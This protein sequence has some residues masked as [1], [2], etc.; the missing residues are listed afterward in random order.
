MSSVL[1]KGGISINPLKIR[2]HNFAAI[3]DCEIDLTQVN[4]ASVIGPNGI[5][6]SSTFV[7]GPSFCLY[8]VSRPGCGL[9][10]LVKKGET[11]MFAQFTFEHNN[12][13]WQ[14]VRTRSL[15]GRGKSSAEFQELVNG[16]WVNRSGKTI[17]ETD[18]IIQQLLGL[19][20]STFVASSL[21]IQG[22]I[23]NFTSKTPSNRK[24]VLTQ[25]L[26]LDLYDKLQSLAKEKSK[27]LELKLEGSKQ[28][29]ERLGE[30]MESIKVI[31]FGLDEV[32]K[33]IALFS[34]D[35][36]QKETEL[37][38]IQ[39]QIKDLEAKQQQAQQIQ[40]KI[41]ALSDEISIKNHEVVT[42]NNRI[43][44]AETVLKSEAELV[45]KTDKLKALRQEIIELETKTARIKELQAE[46]KQL[47]TEEDNLIKDG[48]SLI[49]K[50]GILQRELANK[51]ELKLASEQYQTSLAELKG[52]DE[53]AE[54]WQELQN[55]IIEIEKVT[56]KSGDL[57][58]ELQAKLDTYY[59]KLQNQKDKLAIL[60]NSGCPNPDNATC[61]FLMDA[62][63]A[64][65]MIPKI[66]NEIAELEAQIDDIKT[67]RKPLI[68]QIINLTEQQKAIDYVPDIYVG[69]KQQTEALRLKAE[70]YA[71]LSGKEELLLNLFNQREG[72][73]T[74]ITDNQENQKKINDQIAVLNYWLGTL[75]FKQ[76]E[77]RLLEPCEKQLA[78]IPQAKAVI[79][80]AKEQIKKLFGEIIQK[81]QTQRE[82]MVALDALT[83]LNL[84]DIEIDF[85]YTIKNNY[86]AE[87]IIQQD[88]KELQQSLNALFA[89]QGSLQSQYDTLLA[90]QTKHAELSQQIAPQAKELT[91]WNTLVKA[92][93]K[94]GG[95]PT[96]IL[97]NAL[98]ELE[99]IANDILSQMSNGQHS[100]QF[101]TQRDAKSK[102]SQIETLDI[103]V[104]DW[105][106]TRPFESFSGGEQTRISL[107]I[108]FALSELLA[109]RSGSKIEFIVADEV[110][111]D[112]SPEFRDMTVESIKAL[113]GRFKKIL[114]IS[115]IPEIQAAFDQRI[116]LSEGGKVDIQFN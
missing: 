1:E 100:L 65:Q 21:I 12:S 18:N 76:D 86:Q 37:S 22:D 30:S 42:L 7:Y 52:Q 15:K 107:A 75:S 80:T 28:E 29:L 67:E 85:D 88:L 104:S 103:L 96:L 71:S 26:G 34:L 93:S 116:I 74:R 55:Q 56:D 77:V 110:L 5:S 97:E 106:G 19:D 9:D 57:L 35:I 101:I 113:S 84:G 108:R 25:I 58:H 61:K 14:I 32:K 8:G 3:S 27:A 73:A 87:A 70:Q 49:A 53:K 10:D 89:R 54:K 83:Y 39:A 94:Q 16:Q 45:S 69:I 105:A 64:K 20:Y 4:L 82:F 44:D 81:E 111:S 68:E 36:R 115:H 92:F 59:I 47:E 112:Q 78:E 60:Q 109:N 31:K 13:I 40:E 23:N 91:R 17:A 102:D 99:R 72:L 51:D 95:I 41:D 48:D 90:D 66:A 63:Q 2:L 46:V 114:L 11:D 33:N 38:E 50:I 98:P 62:M 6:K 43:V 24:A 79:E